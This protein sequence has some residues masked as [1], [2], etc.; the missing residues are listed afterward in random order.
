VEVRRGYQQSDVGVIPNDW[1][2]TPA[3]KIGTPVRGGSPRPAGDA[4]YFNGAYI[5]WLTV[6]ALTNIPASRLTVSETSSCL[7]AEGALR[8]RTL[9]PGTLIIANSGATLGVAKILAMKCCANDGIAALLGLSKRVSADYLAHYINSKTDY[10]RDTVATGNGQPNLNTELIGNFTIPL[11]PTKSEQSSIA[12]A[13]SNADVLIES[14]EQLLTKKRQIKQGAMQELLTG[15]E[16]L[17][18]FNLPWESRRLRDVGVFLKGG[19]VTKRQTQSGALACVRYGEIYTRHDERIREFFSWI[20]N[21]VASSATRLRLGDILFAGSGETKEDIGK[22]VAF[23]TDVEAY[24]GGDIIILRPY[25]ADGRFL[26][27]YLNTAAINRQKASRGQGDAVVH[28]SAN[29]L[30]DIQVCL[31]LVPEQTAIAD[32]LSDMD[33][34]ITALQSRLVKA[35]DIKTG[36]TQELLTGRIRL[37]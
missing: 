1:Q 30:A 34:E 19:G 13:L 36:M 24:A 33:D 5:P 29:A 7:T 25:R 37:I 4:R 10:L 21:E 32:V 3:K 18:G 31:P 16:R 27:Y 8:S 20:S 14:L 28:I 6:A 35:K 11:P 9:E 22:C 26:G 12:Q 2:A 15:K 17:S 23:V